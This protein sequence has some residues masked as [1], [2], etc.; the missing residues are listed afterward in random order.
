M[1]SQLDLNH[2]HVGNAIWKKLELFVHVRGLVAMDQAS[3]T[4]NGI[5]CNRSRQFLC[6][7]FIDE[8]TTSCCIRAAEI[9]CGVAAIRGGPKP[10]VDTCAKPLVV[11]SASANA[12]PQPLDRL[13]SEQ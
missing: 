8:E 5:V 4:A 12:S 13:H 2:V 9:S 3:G 1:V 7:I 10:C 6:V 11:S